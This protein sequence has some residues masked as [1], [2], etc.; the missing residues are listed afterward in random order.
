MKRIPKRPTVR[1]SRLA[2]IRLPPMTFA[3]AKRSDDFFEKEEN[4]N[5]LKTNQNFLNKT[6]KL[7]INRNVY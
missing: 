6:I 2:R 3:I 7:E 5:N 1:E 4:H